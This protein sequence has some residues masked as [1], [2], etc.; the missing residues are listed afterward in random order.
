MMPQLQG[1][2]KL[3][4]RDRTRAA[5]MLEWNLCTEDGPEQGWRQELQKMLMLNIKAEMQIL[6]ELP[7]GLVSWLSSELGSYYPEDGMLF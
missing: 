3:T 1:L 5:R 6:D 4:A 2:M 7:G